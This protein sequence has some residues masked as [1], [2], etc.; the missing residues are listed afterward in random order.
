MYYVV[1][2]GKCRK[3]GKKKVREGREEREGLKAG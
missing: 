3:R 1:S 2:A